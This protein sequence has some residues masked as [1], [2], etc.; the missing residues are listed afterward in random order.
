MKNGYPHMQAFNVNARHNKSKKRA[1][2]Q[3]GKDNNGK[4]RNKEEA[5]D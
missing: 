5:V 4:K 2:W 3:L 1:W